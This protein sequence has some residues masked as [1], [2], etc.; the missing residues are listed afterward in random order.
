VVSAIAIL[1]I[2]MLTHSELKL[3]GKDGA[4]TLLLGTGVS[5]L[6]STYSKDRKLRTL[7]ARI[8][9]RLH[10]CLAHP[11]YSEVRHC[12]VQVLAEFELAFKAAQNRISQGV[13]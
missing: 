6:V 1:G 10:A 2:A 11:D 3:V 9:A 7:S 13:L 5:I 12:F 8:R 4:A